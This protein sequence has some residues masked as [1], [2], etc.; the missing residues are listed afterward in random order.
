[1]ARI[2][3]PVTAV[4]VG[5]VASVVASATWMKLFPQ[6]TKADG[7]ESPPEGGEKI[8]PAAPATAAD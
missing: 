5:G 8:A 7:F 6:L 3:G 2:L 1:M 4:V